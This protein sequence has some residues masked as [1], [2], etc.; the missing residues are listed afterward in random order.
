MSSFVLDA[1]ALM[2]VLN[3]ETGD[4]VVEAALI[5]GAA[6]STVNF[7]EVVAK[8]A[9]RAMTEQDIHLTLSPFDLELFDFDR[10]GAFAAGF[11]RSLT[12]RQ[13]VSLGD[14]ACLALA[15]Q[16]GLPALTSDRRWADLDPALGV[17]VRLLR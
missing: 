5:E 16:V 13:G 14:R 8:L 4:S 10:T 9:E 12:R 17:E 2:A 15:A 11:L 1:S 7:S 6:M 3:R